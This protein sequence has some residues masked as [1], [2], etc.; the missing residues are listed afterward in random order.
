M[1]HFSRISFANRYTSPASLSR[2]PTWHETSHNHVSFQRASLI[3]RPITQ[4][5]RFSQSHEYCLG[6]SVV[7]RRPPQAATVQNRHAEDEV[8]PSLP[9]DAPALVASQS[10]RSGNQADIDFQGFW[11]LSQYDERD[12]PQYAS[13]DQ[14]VSAPIDEDEPQR[15]SEDQ[16][17]SAQF[18][19]TKHPE[20]DYH[21][22]STELS[23][24]LEEPPTVAA[25]KEIWTVS[26]QPDKVDLSNWNTVRGELTATV[27]Q[28]R[29]ATG[30]DIFR[31][32]IQSALSRR[33]TKLFAQHYYHHVSTFTGITDDAGLDLLHDLHHINAD[34]AL[35]VI[36]DVLAW[37]WILLA[38]PA[39]SIR[40]LVTLSE[41]RDRNGEPPVPLW[42]VMQITRMKLIDPESLELLLK[43]LASRF[44]LWSWGGDEVMHLTVRLIRHARLSDLVSLKP[45]VNAFLELLDIRFE[46]PSLSN[47]SK[48]A[49]WCNRIL[50]LLAIPA[51]EHKFRAM[52][53]QQSAQLT[54]VSYMQNH[55]PEIPLTRE[56]YRAVAKVQLMHPKTDEERDWARA[57]TLTWP[58]WEERNRMGAVLRPT[59]Y[60]G[61][62]SRAVKVLRRMQE[63]GYALRTFDLAL[64]IMA[65]WDT[66]RSPTIQVA[67]KASLISTPTPWLPEIRNKSTPSIIWAARVTATR[68]LREAWMSFC[69]Y[70]SAVPQ[71][72]QWA[73][74]YHAMFGK[75]FAKTN[76]QIEDQGPLPGDGIEV[77]PDSDLP[78]DRVWIPVDIPSIEELF[79][80]MVKNNIRPSIR[81]LSELIKHKNTTWV[82]GLRY[83]DLLHLE[84]SKKRALMDP[85]LEDLEG[86]R[87]ALASVPEHFARA[88]LDLLVRPNALRTS[89]QAKS[90]RSLLKDKQDD[91][92]LATR[93]MGTST[94]T[95]LWNTFFTSLLQ[96]RR[97][98]DPPRTRVGS[99]TAWE[100][101]CNAL[102]MMDGRV[103]VDFRTSVIIS[104]L[105]Y[106]RQ[107]GQ[108]FGSS[109]NRRQSAV[110]LSEPANSKPPETTV[111]A[112]TIAKRVFTQ[113]ATG[114]RT[115]GFCYFG[116]RPNQLRHIPRG[117]DIEA[118]VWVLGAVQ[119]PSGIK[120]ISKLLAWVVPRR[121]VMLAHGH[122]LTTHN[123]AAFRAFLEGS[124]ARKEE[125]LLD[126]VHVSDDEHSLEMK[127]LAEKLEYWPDHE[128]MEKY[129]VWNSS[130]F[131][132]L[133]K[134]LRHRMQMRREGAQ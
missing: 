111:D 131:E 118:M 75:L 91:I 66:D 9:S 27:P 50:S 114:L 36:E 123:L 104:Q 100:C 105:A 69:S 34:G 132:I 124:W 16:T 83:L 76:P 108:T 130:K 47:Q 102:S 32:D 14:T 72:Q 79:E 115:A 89:S 109:A 49:H 63:A 15:T 95:S 21:R 37:T 112:V 106:Y 70:L 1:Y 116:R 42:V 92:E 7:L 51:S 60:P 81:L 41:S 54:L 38:E 65:G 134:H 127:K 87:Q 122:R 61:R 94:A 12:E 90:Q 58:P 120:D 25:F 35:L 71:D 97:P 10:T 103:E 126:E 98:Y 20:Y 59:S 13:H 99:Y 68:T 53:F 40:R 43:F 128:Y 110:G 57:K 4:Y 33:A 85:R 117:D 18:A 129:L 2:L 55:H 133:K 121:K 11:S 125:D 84:P 77:Y 17:V 78:R 46:N 64:Q 48:S 93:I 5:R 3:Q 6:S 24:M 44:R 113:A 31:G 45:I 8:D 22:P 28:K 39:K 56:G 62:N 80:Q 86:I 67:R 96:H 73:G 52:F 82:Q 23:R 119:T 30:T 101:V 29:L 19:E 107:I 88:Y 74:V 26:T